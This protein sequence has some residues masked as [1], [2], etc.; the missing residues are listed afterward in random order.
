VLR[1]ESSDTLYSAVAQ[2]WTPWCRASCL[3]PRGQSHRQRL[4]V[5][6]PKN[7]SM[8]NSSPDIEVAGVQPCDTQHSQLAYS[9][10]HSEGPVVALG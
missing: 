2:T 4:V 1:P 8:K 5:E 7:L 6:L 3:P 10:S 9:S